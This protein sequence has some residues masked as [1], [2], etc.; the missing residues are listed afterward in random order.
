MSCVRYDF[1]RQGQQNARTW[2]QV[3]CWHIGYLVTN[4]CPAITAGLQV[5][6]LLGKWFVMTI[7]TN[8]FISCWKTI[9]G[10]ANLLDC[11]IKLF[12]SYKCCSFLG[13]LFFLSPWASEWNSS[14]FLNRA[15]CPQ[16]LSKSCSSHCPC[17]SSLSWRLPSSF[18]S[19]FTLR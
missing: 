3:I 13:V 15:V 11:T 19:S 2:F 7:L 5:H 10:K 17:L 16:V 4:V 1:A 8:T 12:F 18:T 6:L 14:K 9:K